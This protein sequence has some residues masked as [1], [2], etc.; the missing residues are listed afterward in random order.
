MECRNAR[1]L[2]EFARP[3][4]SEL[5]AVE[6]EALGQH[7]SECP[8][9]SALAQF[10]RRVDD[11]LGRAMRDVPVPSGL[12]ER[13]LGKLA[14]ERS[15][16]NRRWL[17]RASAAAAVL[18]LGLTGWYLWSSNLPALTPDDV[19]YLVGA[20]PFVEPDELRAHSVGHWDI[21][22]E[23]PPRFNPKLLQSYDLAILQG[24]QVP[25]L[26]FARESE[27]PRH[28]PD[29]ARVYIL[30]RRQFD[31]EQTRKNFA[32]LSGHHEVKILDHLSEPGQYLYL[33]ICPRG[34]L[35]RFQSL[36]API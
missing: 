1:L 29:V 13:I 33:V 22:A 12:R 32:N 5:D 6:A 7:L 24:R 23:L 27:E 10:E 8:D 17:L 18:L 2:L 19:P 21:A 4:S 34:K 25:L 15:L 26:V 30:S 36:S 16:R 9:C 20:G 35:H 3:G 31:L 11:H 14:G 28:R